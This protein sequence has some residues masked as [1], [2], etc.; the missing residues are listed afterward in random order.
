MT[1][2][3][4][5][6]GTEL[7]VLRDLVDF[8]GRH[9]LEVGCG[10]GRLTWQYARQARSVKGIDPDR[11]RIDD[12]RRAQPEDLREKVDFHPLSLQDFAQK[13]QTCRWELILLSWSL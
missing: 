4:D 3:L 12:A 10:D 6:E 9:I 11:E 8:S 13:E 2:L 1:V 5:P 7:S